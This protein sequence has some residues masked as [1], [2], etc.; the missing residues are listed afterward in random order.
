M[1]EQQVNLMTHSMTLSMNIDFSTFY[2]QNVNRNV[3]VDFEQPDIFTMSKLEN[4]TQT[5]R[6][7]WKNW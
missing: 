7:Y 1:N 4:P 3:I 6:N 5:N 2:S